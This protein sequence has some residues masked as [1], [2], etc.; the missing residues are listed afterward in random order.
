MDGIRTAGRRLRL[1]KQSRGS[2]T[3][4]VCCVAMLARVPAKAAAAVIPLDAPQ[5]GV[6]ALEAA[7][8][9]TMLT[10]K[11]RRV[12][13]FREKPKIHDACLWEVP[14]A[15]VVRN[16]FRPGLG[17]HWIVE[18]GKG[19]IFDPECHEGPISIACYAPGRGMRVVAAVITAADA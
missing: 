13:R 10:G 1:V 5:R 11:K 15:V 3:C 19:N 18:D 17:G 7:K 12:V 14:S 8:A 2:A 9:L 16:V 4:G 6:S